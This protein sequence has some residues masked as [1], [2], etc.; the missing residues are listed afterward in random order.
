MWADD[1]IVPGEMIDLNSLLYPETVS[2]PC[3]AVEK[4]T[5]AVISGNFSASV[6]RKFNNLQSEF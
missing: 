6:V 1:S 3:V 5:K 4:G 2:K